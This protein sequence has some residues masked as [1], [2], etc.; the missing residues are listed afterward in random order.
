M[1][2]DT[3]PADEKTPEAIDPAVR[4]LDDPAPGLAVDTADHGR[5]TA[6][7]NVRNDP[8][9]TNSILATSIV[10]ALVE[11]EMLRPTGAARTSHNNRVEGVR[12]HP[13]VGDVRP[14]CHNG[15][16]HAI[17]VRQKMAF[18]ARFCAIGGVRTRLVPPFGA[19][20]IELSRLVHSRFKPCPCSYT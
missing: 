6:A 19:F 5:L 16:R 1:S 12:H 10:I 4:S 8:A 18:D 20:T 11:A 13:H 14:G 9:L 7:T 15:D 2:C 3:L 17:G